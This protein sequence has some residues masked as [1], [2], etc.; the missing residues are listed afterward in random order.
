MTLVRVN[1][2]SPPEI[3]S[4]SDLKE[5]AQ[6]LIQYVCKN[7]SSPNRH[8]PTFVIQPKTLE[9]IGTHQWFS[10][11]HYELTR[12]VFRGTLI[13]AATHNH[14]KYVSFMLG[15]IIDLY[16]NDRALHAAA[17]LHQEKPILS[18]DIPKKLEDNTACV[19]YQMVVLENWQAGTPFSFLPE[20]VTLLEQEMPDKMHIA[21]YKDQHD[22]GVLAQ[23]LYAIYGPWHV[24]I[25]EW[26]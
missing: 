17:L 1:E 21:K 13:A 18:S 24:K 25:A 12:S 8:G 22:T 23:V 9:D 20:V 10:A 11:E 15:A 19:G 14:L 3:A 5:E 6:E 2:P 4:S 26:T 7:T 16:D